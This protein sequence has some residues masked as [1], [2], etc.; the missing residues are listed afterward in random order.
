MKGHCPGSAFSLRLLVAIP[1]KRSYSIAAFCFLLTSACK[2][3]PVQ[4]DSGQAAATSA[5]STQQIYEGPTGEVRGTV[6]I[7]GDEPPR[8]PSASEIPVGKCYKAHERHALLFRKAA[9]GGVA[10]AIVAVTEYQGK[11]PV[12]ATPF[13]VTMDDCSLSHRTIAIASGQS[14]H[15]KNRGPSAGMPQLVGLPTPAV[16]VA[17]P[18]GDPVVLTPHTVGQFE[19]VDRSHPFATADVFVV[20][21]PTITVSDEKGAFH[22][23][24]VPAG[25]AKVSV[26]LPATG[27]TLQ[28][29]V[30]IAA[31]QTTDVTFELEF[32]LERHEAAVA[33]GKRLESGSATTAP[34][35][36]QP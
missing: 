27:L 4:N 3:K 11:L 34:A 20:N 16:M 25:R 19:L 18:G 24:G 28:K 6:R 31:G 33:L 22:I 1:M 30:D 17:V 12:P 8:L 26:R 32:S 10:D 23:P 9:D 36:S 29:Q 5:A 35:A 2:D 21:Y 15:V 13:V 14:I 7:V